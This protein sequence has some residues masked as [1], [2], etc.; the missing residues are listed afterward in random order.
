MSEEFR[1]HWPALLA[2]VFGLMTSCLVLMGYSIGLFVHPL[3]DQFGWTRQQILTA[4]S[5]VTLGVMFSGVVVGW[6]ADRISVATLILVSQ[7]GLGLSILALAFFTNGNL[8]VY[9]GIYL[10]IAF[11]GAGA[12]PVTFTK[13][14]SSRFVRHRGLAIGICLAGTGLCGVVVPPLVGAFIRVYGWRIGY[15]ALATLPLCVAMPMTLIFLRGG[16]TA[17]AKTAAGGT[18]ATEDYG[19]TLSEAVRSRRFWTIVVALFLASGSGAGFLFSMVPM[20]ID[21][22]YESSAAANMSAIFGVAVICGRILI[23]ALAD[24]IWVPPL[25]LTVLAS[26]ALATLLIS[27][28]TVALAMALVLIFVIGLAQG[29]EGDMLAYLVSQY[30]GLRAYGKIFSWVFVAFT[31]AIGIAGP[32]FGHIF[33]VYRSYGVAMIGSSAAWLMAGLLLVS[34]GPYPKWANS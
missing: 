26:A 2:S 30:F 3:A 17:S 6:L 9:Y 22:G 1:R 28:V 25:A 34:L 8:A 10:L 31:A 24:R 11:V 29:A 13:L 16:P 33:D 27:Q 19:L 20:L 4:T 7:L 21:R 18:A 12:L 32:L 5:I 14:L 15:L 23:G